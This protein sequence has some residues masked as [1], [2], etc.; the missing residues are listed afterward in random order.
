MLKTIKLIGGSIFVTV[1]MGYPLPIMP[2]YWFMFPILMILDFP[3]IL[4][5]YPPLLIFAFILYYL[6]VFLL[7]G[8]T[9]SFWK[10]KIESLKN[11]EE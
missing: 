5:I 8:F 9:I 7:I 3:I 2:M 6:L 1:L 4:E 11:F 10:R